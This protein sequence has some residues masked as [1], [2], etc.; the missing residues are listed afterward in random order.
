MFINDLCVFLE[1]KNGV[2]ITLDELVITALLFAD[3]MVIFSDTR[4]GLQKGLDAMKEYCYMWSLEVNTS[5]TKCVAFKK[6]GKIGRE[7]R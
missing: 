4:E 7:E 2:G 1:N 6:G 3:D 5:K